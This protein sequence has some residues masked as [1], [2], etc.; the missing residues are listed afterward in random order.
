MHFTLC[1]T[2]LKE[3]KNL[4]IP[5]PIYVVNILIDIRNILIQIAKP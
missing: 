3:K 5:K 2:A 1:V 4:L